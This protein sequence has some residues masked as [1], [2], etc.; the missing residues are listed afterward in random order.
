MI[1]RAEVAWST[2]ASNVRLA[3]GLYRYQFDFNPLDPNEPGAYP[4]TVE[5]GDWFLDYSGYPF[6]IEEISGNTLTVYDVNERGNGTTSAYGP[7][8]NM[9]G[10]VYRPVNGAFM[11]NQAQLRKLDASAADVINNIEKGILWKYRGLSLADTTPIDNI[12]NLE[13]ENIDII[14]VT[15]EG[16]QGG[17]KVKLR[18]SSGIEYTT[19]QQVGHGFTFDV[20]YLDSLTGLWTKALADNEE[21]CGTHIAIRVD[22]DNFTIINN[23]EYT[24]TSDILDEDNNPLIPGEYYFLSQINPGK[25]TKVKPE[26]GITQ[27][28][29]QALGTQFVSINVEEPYEIGD[30]KEPPIIAKFIDLT[31]T[32]SNYED[33]KFVVAT[34]DSIVYKT[35]LIS[36]ISGLQNELDLKVNV[37]D[38]EDIDVLNKIKNVHG[39]GSG[40][41]ADLLDGYEADVFFKRIGFVA[42]FDTT[43]AEGYYKTTVSSINCPVAANY[44]HILLVY[45]GYDASALHQI[46]YTSDSIGGDIWR[47][48]TSDGGTSWG[49]WEKNYNTG[50]ANL[51]TVDWTTK[52]LTTNG[53]TTIQS[54]NGLIL[55]TSGVLSA[56][57]GTQGDIIY[58]NGTNWVTLAAGTNGYY[59]KTQGTGAN[60]IWAASTA[61][62]GGSDTYVQ[63]NDGGNFGGV[64]DLTFDKTS[65]AL[66]CG[67][68]I[69][70]SNI[71]TNAATLSTK[72]GI[73]AGNN[74]D[75]SAARRNTY[76][77]YQAGYSGTTGPNDCVSVGYQAGYSNTD[78][79]NTNVGAQSGYT[80]SAASNRINLGYRAGYYETGSLKLFIDAL[81]RTNEATARTDS[82]IY[83]V[84]N[85]T[86]SSQELYLNSKLFARHLTNASKTNCLYY[87]TST[88]EISYGAAPTG[89]S[90]P[91]GT[92][93]DILYHNGTAWT[94]LPAGTSGWCLKTFGVGNN[95]MWNPVADGFIGQVQVSNG[96]GSNVSYSNF[97]YNSS[98]NSLTLNSS[99]D[100]KL[101]ILNNSNNPLIFQPRTGYYWRFGFVSTG[102]RIDGSTTSDFASF[103]SPIKGYLDGAVE[104]YHNSILRLSTTNAG[105]SIPNKLFLGTTTAPATDTGTLN[106]L[107]W[108]SSTGEVKQRAITGGGTPG[109]SDTYVQFNSGGAFEGTP[110]FS[111][112]DYLDA[113]DVLHIKN[114]GGI[115]FYGTTGGISAGIML[116]SISTAGK[117][118]IGLNSS[119]D[120]I[121][122]DQNTIRL[123]PNASVKL[124]DTAS[125][126]ELYL[127]TSA[128]K[129]GMFGTSPAKK[130]SVT[131]PSAVVTTETADATYSTNEVNMLNNLKTDVTNLQSKLTALIDALQSYGLI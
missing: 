39:D 72:L 32:P 116:R 7:Y 109:G 33:G 19:I 71:K 131:D 27:Y 63:F 69:T 75:E 122:I 124:C 41:D 104:L 16:W 28:I 79:Y 120:V 43:I 52:N 35:P 55:G 108:D 1:Y 15:E 92:Q 26:E 25:L 42:D 99:G 117:L 98:A 106:S 96:S 9:I 89:G 50:N 87:D 4:T 10:Y 83:G 8:N 65:K 14:D 81:D 38:Y 97:K 114:S 30:I 66:T 68:V 3:T 102:F 64:V 127:G 67:G 49:A 57:T 24:Y 125:E 112:G 13:L 61:T 86:A 110:Y 37:S 18:A 100:S 54:L 34:I 70:G 53:T 126:T 12:T 85:S 103:S 107:V 128:T 2:K 90:I 40:L 51:S 111:I 48:Y 20:V 11:L 44:G 76:L 58:Y 91:A 95:P 113:Y 5:V 31:D 123:L 60:P 22:D 101:L 119:G 62:P 80:G 21:T 36:D 94:V 78:D 56:I 6:L 118:G 74:E 59:L 45:R 46:L 84:M 115:N 29:L 47:R 17:K 130:T 82:I 73:G 121:E 77:G 105:I 93:G 129:I 23:G 88:K